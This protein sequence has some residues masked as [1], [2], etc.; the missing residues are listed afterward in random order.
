MTDPL[1]P[2][3][4]AEGRRIYDEWQA[5]LHG[6]YR[7]L[8]TWLRC[9]APV[10][11]DM[12][13]SLGMIE[14]VLPPTG[15]NGI[16]LV[17]RLTELVVQRNADDERV[18]AYLKELEA[19]AESLAAL[20]TERDALRQQLA[21]SEQRLDLVEEANIAAEATLAKIRETVSAFIAQYNLCEPAITAAFQM[22]QIHGMPYRGPNFGK[23]L[24]ALKLLA[25][26]APAKET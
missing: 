6:T 25:D 3:Q 8:D 1:T 2:Q 24:T 20:T 12:A 7:K 14:R 17:D 15:R 9:H 11:L 10:L 13:E 22:Q 19:A 4:V 23:E 21:T 5:G 18:N 26:P 16:E